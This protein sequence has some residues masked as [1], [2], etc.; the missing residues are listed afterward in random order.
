MA[1]FSRNGFVLIAYGE[2]TLCMRLREKMEKQNYETK[3][4]FVEVE[5]EIASKLELFCFLKDIPMKYF[6]TKTIENELKPYETLLENAR[7]LK[8]SFRN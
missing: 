2:I 3:R 4:R 1:E 7:K 5:K 8:F 6:A